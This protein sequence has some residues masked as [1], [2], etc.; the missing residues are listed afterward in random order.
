MKAKNV[1]IDSI[2]KVRVGRLVI[3]GAMALIVVF[4]S[5]FFVLS[6]QSHR[7]A[8]EIVA[9]RLNQYMG[10]L[11][12]ELALGD[13]EIGNSIFEDFVSR[14]AALGAKPNLKLNTD[15]DLADLSGRTCV[16]SMFGADVNQAVVFGGRSLG[17]I[18][19][20]V[21]YFQRYL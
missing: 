7:A 2:L 14:I 5:Q 13:I 9:A 1:S 17:R 4:A 12:R 11:S 19:G 3:F 15:G 16:P 20:R 6:Y 21:T 8:C 10:P 18:T